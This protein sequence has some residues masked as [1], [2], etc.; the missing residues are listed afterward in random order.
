LR[1]DQIAQ[2]VQPGRSIEP[3]VALRPAYDAL[4]SDYLDLYQDSRRVVHRLAGRQ[5]TR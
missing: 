3:D 1:R 5:A 4:Y 2:W